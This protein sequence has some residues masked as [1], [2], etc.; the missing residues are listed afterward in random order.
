VAIHANS[1]VLVMAFSNGVA[2]YNLS[3]SRKDA[4][5]LFAG[6]NR[7]AVTPGLSAVV[8]DSTVSDFSDVN[9]AQMVLYRR[10]HSVSMSNGMKAFVADFSVPS[11]VHAVKPL[12]KLMVTKDANAKRVADKVLKTA[13]ALTVVQAAHGGYQQILRRRLTAWQQ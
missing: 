5:T 11:A 8:T 7:V 13:A 6:N 9:P 10:V 3:D 1:V 12:K 4:V 2:V